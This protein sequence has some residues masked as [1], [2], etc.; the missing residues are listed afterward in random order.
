[1]TND[2]TN[3]TTDDTTDETTDESR[4]R[5]AADRPWD[6]VVAGGG[7]AGLAAALVLSRARRRVLVVDAGSPRN[8]PA[9][10]A[11]GFLTRD[12]I[13]PRA[14]LAH[15]RDEVLG[16]G[17]EIV[18]G[19]VTAVEGEIGAFTVTL[20][21]G[22]RHAAR[23]FVS[24]TGGRDTLPDVPGLA[25]RW[26]RDV[27]HCPYCHGWEVGDGRVV[28]AAAGPLG[29][30][31]A[32]LWRQWTPH[33]TL[34]RPD[35]ALPADEA[36]R[37]AARGVRVALG[38]PAE[39]V[40]TDDRLTAVRSDADE[41]L[42]AD[43]LVVR[44]VLEA[45][46]A[47]LAPLGLT[48]EPVESAGTV[49]ARAVPTDAWGG[50]GVPGVRVAGNVSDPAATVL[51]SAA[52][53]ATVAGML[54]AELVELDAREAV[55]AWRRLT[56]GPDATSAWSLDADDWEERY[57]TAHVWSGRPN[58][59]LVE[60]TAHLTPG[61]AL[62]L[63]AG[64]GRDAVWLAQQGWRVTAVDFAATALAR[65]AHAAQD[66]GV[67]VR[68]VQADLATL[69]ARDLDGDV[70]FDLVTSHF[71]HLAPQARRGHVAR[72]ARLV[73]PGGTLLLV[74]HHALD[75]AAPLGRP[76]DPSMFPGADE[77]RD[78]LLALDA[79][80]TV[81]VALAVPRHATT[82]DGVTVTVHDAVLRARR[83]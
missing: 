26:G 22:T 14:L 35:A 44:T 70:S 77:V 33:V 39:L 48:A 36:A 61:T 68:W 10:H 72:A 31:A 56:S 2:T 80:W 71:L 9:A 81:E 20:E 53:G 1:M 55:D 63:G 64:E 24:A 23:A 19:R 75:L 42:A 3:D 41:T 83:A 76:D 60:Q 38:R 50:T 46:V 66:A 16:Y 12:G 57:G 49:V 21:D 62:D 28:V 8:A 45:D 73:A 27:L 17:G 34:L 37:L 4:G 15:G 69:D 7:P 5:A 67:D 54:N 6:V 78:E 18:P 32:L 13:P 11:H 79:S 58:A 74:Q 40:V 30:H 47:H 82:H 43:A 59:A 52:Q 65:G 51:V 25:Q 29:V